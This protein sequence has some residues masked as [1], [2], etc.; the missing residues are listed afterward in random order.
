[1]LRACILDF[2]RSWE[3]HLPLVE[4]AYNN[5]HHSSI[6]MAPYEALYGQKCRTPL[7]W[8][9]TREIGLIRPEIVQT[10][11]DK[12]KR[13]QEKMRTSQSR[14]KSYAD[15]RRRNLEFS[16]GDKVYLKVSPFKSVIR[17][18]R[19]GKLSPRYI[20]PYEILERIGVVAYRIALPVALSNIHNVFHVS[21]LRKHEPDPTQILRNKTIEIQNDLTY[22][23]E[24][25][26][27]LDQRDQVLRNKVIPLV[28][29]LWSNHDEEEATWEREEEMKISYP[30][31]F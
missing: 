21:Q 25:V 15:Q 17:G 3:K 7:C 11:T 2:S 30:H 5:G 27:I 8:V 26:R 31:L 23:E 24:P 13:I 1:M 12:I 10:T 22:P 29:V 19:K 18:K 16:I 9:E 6:G 4:F 20:G 14:Q 28:K